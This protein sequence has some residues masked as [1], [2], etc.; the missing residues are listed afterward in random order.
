[1]EMI[2]DIW[3]DSSVILFQNNFRIHNNIYVVYTQC[4]SDLSFFKINENSL[5]FI[6]TQKLLQT[7]II[8]RRW[9]RR[10]KVSYRKGLES[11]L[12]MHELRMMIH[13]LWLITMLTGVVFLRSNWDRSDMIHRRL[14]GIE[15]LAA[16][17]QRIFPILTTVLLWIQTMWIRNFILINRIVQQIFWGAFPTRIGWLCHLISEFRIDSM[18]TAATPIDVAWRWSHLVVVDKWLL[19]F[20]NAVCVV[21]MWI[22]GMTV[23]PND[24][25]D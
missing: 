18:S 23:T 11:L 21:L 19:D 15:I 14:F 4:H 3:L 8:M 6:I 17:A 12:L 2:I 20:W 5:T 22:C 13:S 24:A 7:W 1:M 25:G 9:W 16:I 10:W